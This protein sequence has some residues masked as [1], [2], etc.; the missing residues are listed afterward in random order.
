[1]QS[2]IATPAGLKSPVNIFPTDTELV[3]GPVMTKVLKS[4]R[5]WQILEFAL[6]ILALQAPVNTDVDESK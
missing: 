4:R 5:I 2:A 1:M 3:E 6:Q